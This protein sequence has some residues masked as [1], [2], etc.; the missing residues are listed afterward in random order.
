VRQIFTSPHFR[1]RILLEDFTTIQ[2]ALP[3]PGHI[4][5]QQEDKSARVY[6]DYILFNQ[7]AKKKIS[8]AAL[9]YHIFHLSFFLFKHSGFSIAFFSFASRIGPIPFFIIFGKTASDR[10]LIYAIPREIFNK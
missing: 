2:L 7:T 4:T 1:L 5:S 10:N 3:A 8:L 6:R 9:A